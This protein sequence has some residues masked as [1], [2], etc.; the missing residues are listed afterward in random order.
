MW[1]WSTRVARH[2]VAA[3][4]TRPTGEPAPTIVDP[5]VWTESAPPGHERGDDGSAMR[6]PAGEQ[7][8]SAGRTRLL[9]DY[10]LVA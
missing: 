7:A 10:R 9:P 8:V 3:A 1:E 4:W 2:A 6:N 5:E